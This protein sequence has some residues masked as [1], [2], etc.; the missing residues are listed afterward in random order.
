M[1]SLRT[2][3]GAVDGARVEKPLLQPH[4]DNGGE[5]KDGPI[6]LCHGSV[7]TFEIGG[8]IRM[9]KGRQGQGRGQAE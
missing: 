1:R 7:G 3:P 8:T 5:G 4:Q 6:S 2:G 9:C